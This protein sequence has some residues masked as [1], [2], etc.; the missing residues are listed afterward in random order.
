MTSNFTL[1]KEGFTLRNSKGFSLF[2]VIAAMGVFTIAAATLF[3]LLIHV[4]EERASIR[5]QRQALELLQNH[6]QI[7]IADTDTE[8]AE[9]E[10]VEKGRSYRFS[11]KQTGSKN[12]LKLCVSWKASNERGYEKCGY[13]KRPAAADSP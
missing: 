1:V 10:V 9:D 13:G 7:W 6:I 12:I 3:P 5:E 2:E 8:I 4:Y 11:A